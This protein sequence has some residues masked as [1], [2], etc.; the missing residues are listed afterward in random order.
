MKLSHYAV[1]HPAVIG[2]ILT[3]A[4]VFGFI[5]LSGMNVAFVGKLSLP[6]VAVI[7]VYPGAG[8]EEVEREVTDILEEDFVTLSG[9][10][11]IKSS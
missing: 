3:A 5:S 1:K 9:V 6:S 7:T 8:A 2:M 11:D 4:I 10:K